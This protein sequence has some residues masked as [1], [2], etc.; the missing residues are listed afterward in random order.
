MPRIVGRISWITAVTVATTALA[1]ASVTFFTDPES[2]EQEDA[3]DVVSFKDAR[4]VMPQAR[5]MFVEMLQRTPNLS[6]SA[7]VSP[8]GRVF[9]TNTRKDWMV[10]EALKEICF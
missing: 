9:P 6:E 10:E 4:L 5:D 3:M 7:Y 8:T 1:A 2:T